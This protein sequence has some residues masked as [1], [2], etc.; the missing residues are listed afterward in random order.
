MTDPTERSNGGSSSASSLSVSSADIVSDSDSPSL[1]SFLRSPTPSLLARKR[2]VQSNRPP[3]PTGAKRCKGETSSDPKHVKPLDRVTQY[4]GEQ[5]VVSVGKLFCSACR[6]EISTKKSIIDLHIKSAKHQKGK[7]RVTLK[8]K[9]E[10]SIAKALK[11]FDSRTHAVGEFLPDS[12]R[13]FRVKVV[14]SFLKA[15]IPLMK[16]DSLRELFEENGYSLSSSTHLRQVLP[17]IWHEEIA[18]IKEEISGRP[19]L[20]IF[21]GTTHVAEAFVLVLR[22]VDD[23]LVKQRVCRL[24][25]LAKSLAGEEIARLLVEILS[26]EL[27]I[28]SS[29]VVAAMRDRASVNSVAMRTVS[30]LYCRV[31]D[32]GCF[33][34][35]LDHVGERMNTPVLD[36]FIKTWI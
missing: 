22:F 36:T 7:E 30:I 29:L 16:L 3:P 25:L 20:I 23:W 19:V 35:T 9:S 32:V 1:L 13:V 28:A 5:F 31:L 8:Q 12:T 6:E 17:F 27:G 24:K 34:H 18:K 2:K 10:L 21:D 33:S 11:C 26:T 15:G 4:P 14:R